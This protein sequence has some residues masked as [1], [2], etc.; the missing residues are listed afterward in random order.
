MYVSL[1]NPKRSF[2]L[3]PVLVCGHGSLVETW[4]DMLPLIYNISFRDQRLVMID[5]TKRNVQGSEDGVI[6]QE[7]QARVEFQSTNSR[8][9][10]TRPIL[11]DLE[12]ATRPG[13][14]SWSQ[15]GYGLMIWKRI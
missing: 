4:S 1:E 6:R 14:K 7:E 3:I 11:R 12:A 9:C 8:G 10:F 13:E 5:G 15:I 2:S